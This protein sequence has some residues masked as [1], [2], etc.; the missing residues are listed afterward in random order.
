MLTILFIFFT[1][2]VSN[3]R[4]NVVEIV[5]TEILILFYVHY[6]INMLFIFLKNNLFRQLPVTL[7]RH[8][9]LFD[10]GSWYVSRRRTNIIT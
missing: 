7:F 8:I 9:T 3:E 4:T 5:L 2:A 1:S 10:K 6:H